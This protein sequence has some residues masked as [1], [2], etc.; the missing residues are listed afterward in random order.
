MS[1]KCKTLIRQGALIQWRRGGGL[2]FIGSCDG[3]SGRRVA[4]KGSG[5]TART[6]SGEARTVDMVPTRISTRNPFLARQLSA[7]LSQMAVPQLAVS[8]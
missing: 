4:E 3:R 1:T 5:A 8:C 7:T 6:A 2:P